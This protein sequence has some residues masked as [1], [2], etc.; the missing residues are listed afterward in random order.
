MS[1]ASDPNVAAQ[2]LVRRELDRA[3][4]EFASNSGSLSALLDAG[5]V[6]APE[7]VGVEFGYFDGVEWRMEWDTEVEGGLPV[8]I[9][10]VL[11]LESSAARRAAEAQG[12]TVN[13][14]AAN[15]ANLDYYRLVVSLPDQCD[16]HGSLR[17]LWRL[18]HGL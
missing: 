16:D 14:T 15:E 5:K 9:Q 11:A 3:V 17:V 18:R 6:I 4:A 1:L 7:I 12:L 2:G 8:A 13:S 10:V